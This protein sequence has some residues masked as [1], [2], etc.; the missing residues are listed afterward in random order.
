MPDQYE[1][2]PCRS[3]AEQD[4][5]VR[6]VHVSGQY[7]LLHALNTSTRGH[8]TTLRLIHATRSSP[9]RPQLVIGMI[10]K[11]SPGDYGDSV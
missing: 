6:S 9:I 2:N 7:I 5:D 4:D 1:Q 3:L 8:L 11:K 10:M